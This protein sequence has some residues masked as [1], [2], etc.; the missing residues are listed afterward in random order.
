M[1]SFIKDYFNKLPEDLQL[2]IY[3]RIKYPQNKNLILD[4]KTFYMVKKSIYSEYLSNVSSIDNEEDYYNNNNIHSCIDNDLMRF[5]NDNINYFH[6]KT[7]INEIRMNRILAYRIKYKL[8]N[9]KATFN[10]DRNTKTCPKTHINRYIGCLNVD[11]RGEL[12]TYLNV[13]CILDE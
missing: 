2:D 9:S 3:S 11:E 4:I 13:S 1:S 6:E 10:F 12:L 5:F 7:R 8:Y